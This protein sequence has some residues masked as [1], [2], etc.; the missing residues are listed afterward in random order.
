MHR[1]PPNPSDKTRMIYT[2]HMIEGGA[3]YDAKNWLQ[4]TAAMPF[5]ALYDVNK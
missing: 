3:E 4:P 5:P 2:F 1:S